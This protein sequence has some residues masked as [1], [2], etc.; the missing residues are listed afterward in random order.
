MTTR[1]I[2]H[3]ALFFVILVSASLVV[4]GQTKPVAETQTAASK[5]P[6]SVDIIYTGKLYGYFRLPSLQ[7]IN[8]KPGC[9]EGNKDTD[10]RSA[11]ADQFFLKKE[12]HLRRK[13]FS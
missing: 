2:F 5:Q 9:R 1:P 13:R 8:A 6:T 7:N 10:P 4:N 11:A 12:S 3:A